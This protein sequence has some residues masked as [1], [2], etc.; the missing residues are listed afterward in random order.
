MTLRYQFEGRMWADEGP[1]G[2]HFVT[3]PTELTEG[4]RAVRSKNAARRVEARIGASSW[5]TALF[6]HGDAYV[7][8]VKGDVRRREAISVGDQVRATIEFGS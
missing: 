4:I 6:P 3:L 8:P 5:N 7:L 2:W 1:G